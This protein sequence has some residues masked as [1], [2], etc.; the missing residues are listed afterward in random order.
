MTAWKE[1]TIYFC[2]FASEIY[3]AAIADDYD[4]V[5]VLMDDI[6]PI[7]TVV[8]E[9]GTLFNQEF[10]AKLMD[11]SIDSV[12]QIRDAR[13]INYALLVVFMGMFVLVVLMIT[14]HA[15][16]TPAVFLSSKDPILP[17]PN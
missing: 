10:G 3:D 11:I 13:V 2:D 6:K 15:V 16:S 12:N 17:L 8:E 1:E 14:K 9:K 4:T 5:F 7:K